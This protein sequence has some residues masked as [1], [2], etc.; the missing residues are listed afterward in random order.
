M[1]A[2]VLRNCS[3]ARDNIEMLYILV[4]NCGGNSGYMKHIPIIR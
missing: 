2:R 4:M 3:I 1:L